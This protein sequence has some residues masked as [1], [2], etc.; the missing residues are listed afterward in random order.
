MAYAQK[1][2]KVWR[3][4]YRDRSGK[5]RTAGTHP[6]REEALT[7]AQEAEPRGVYTFREWWDRWYPSWTASE[8][9][10][11]LE[12][13][14]ATKHTLARWGSTR[15]DKITPAQVQAWITELGTDT[16]NR[17]ALSASTVKKLISVMSTS[18]NAA[19]LE[20]ELSVN[21]CT[22]TKKP[23]LPPTP[24]RYLTNNEC[25]QIRARIEELRPDFLVLF[26]LMLWT[27]MRF[28]E[29]TALHWSQVDVGKRVIEV[30]WS[31]DRQ[32]GTFKPPKSHQV[33]TVPIPRKLVIEGTAE[34][35]VLPADMYRG[36]KRPQY[37]LVTGS[38]VTYVEWRNVWRQ[39]TRGLG[40]VRTHDL[41][42]T[43][44]SRVVSAGQPLQVA[45]KLLGHSTVQMTERYARFM[46]DYHASALAA[47][48]SL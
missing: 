14:R 39:A 35:N 3:A 18:L 31:W 4:M 26:D 28:G 44:A 21:P 6:T 12:K 34:A 24:E 10:K 27:G 5:V 37:G 13:G 33:R 42:H 41:R 46:P 43:Y 11:K 9:T 20:G 30:R 2:G 22:A 23:K 1:R 25:D 38:R 7:A 16:D 47:L 48:D 36:G 29:A 15:I 17:K 19:V 32:T 8:A 45:Q 40:E